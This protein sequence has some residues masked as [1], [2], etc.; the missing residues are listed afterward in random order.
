[1][2]EMTAEEI[3]DWMVLEQIEP[4]GQAREDLRFAMLASAIVNAA[5]VKK[6]DGGRLAAKDFLEALNVDRLTEA[7]SKQQ[8][9]EKIEAMFR[10][11]VAANNAFWERKERIA[12]SIGGKM[13]RPIGVRSAVH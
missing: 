13:M 3:F 1:M 2:R 10:M 6:E 9:P 7:D 4:W 11:A 8:T 5:G 12:R